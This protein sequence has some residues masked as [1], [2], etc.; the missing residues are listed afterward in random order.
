MCQQKWDP[1]HTE[2]GAEHWYHHGGKLCGGS[3]DNL[4]GIPWD[5]GSTERKRNPDTEIFTCLCLLNAWSLKVTKI[6][7]IS[8]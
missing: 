6:L 4:S 7:I 3:S 2:G 5:P 8:G 1:Q